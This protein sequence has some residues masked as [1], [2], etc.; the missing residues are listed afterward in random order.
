M[1][2]SLNSSDVGSTIKVLEANNYHQWQDLMM[3][4]FLEHNP[5]GIVDGTKPQPPAE[6]PDAQN[7]KLRQ[8]RA[9]GFLAGKLDA[10]NGDQFINDNTRRDPAALWTAIQLEYASKKA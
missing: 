6:S 5:E 10:A 7:W 8:K 2:N 1:S 3:P 4:F 9:A